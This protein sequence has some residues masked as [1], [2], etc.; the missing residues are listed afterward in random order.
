MARDAGLDQRSRLVQCLTSA[1]LIRFYSIVNMVVWGTVLVL[2]Q[3]VLP[4]LHGCAGVIMS[5][6]GIFAA[7]SK[8]QESIRA[9]L[10]QMLVN[11]VF[12]V[13]MGPLAVENIYLE[14]FSCPVSSENA[15]NRIEVDDQVVCFGTDSL[16]ERAFALYG[17]IL[18]VFGAILQL[19]IFMF[20]V[21]FY[22]S[23]TRSL[24]T[25]AQV[26]NRQCCVAASFLVPVCCIL[27]HGPI[28]I[29]TRQYVL[30]RSDGLSP[31]ALIELEAIA[32]GR[33]AF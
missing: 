15:T 19:P 11:L 16:C 26:C 24:G 5:L 27:L 2:S 1:S 21:G 25:N 28:A 30:C 14:C 20:T 17:W 10:V 3:G 29:N 8:N 32:R 4:V 22:F 18:I 23:V 9:F 31:A 33:P 7:A 12:C 6:E 13:I